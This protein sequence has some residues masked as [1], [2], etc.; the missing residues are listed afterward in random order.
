MYTSED[1]QVLAE[2]RKCLCS[3]KITATFWNII[4]LFKG[5]KSN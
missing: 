1:K 4:R 5:R 2:D 3:C